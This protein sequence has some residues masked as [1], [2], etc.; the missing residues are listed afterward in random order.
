MDCP[1]STAAWP[2]QVLSAPERLREE[3]FNFSDHK[4]CL[5]AKPYVSPDDGGLAGP[6]CQ[7]IHSC[8]NM[9]SQWLKVPWCP[10]PSGTPMVAEIFSW[11]RARCRSK[12]RLEP[13]NLPSWL[14]CHL[15]FKPLILSFSS[16][17]LASLE[18]V[19]TGGLRAVG[20]RELT[21]EPLASSVRHIPW[22]LYMPH[23]FPPPH[24]AG[25]PSA[26]PLLGHG[27]P[28]FMPS[29]SVILSPAL[30]M[31]PSGWTHSPHHTIRFDHLPFN[32]QTKQKTFSSPSITRQASSH[33]LDPLRRV[34][35]LPHACSPQNTIQPPLCCL[36]SYQ[37]KDL[38]PSLCWQT[39][40][41]AFFHLPWLS[42]SFQWNGP[43]SLLMCS[44][45]SVESDFLQHPQAPL[46]M[47]ILQARVLEWVAMPSSRGSSQPRDQISISYIAGEPRTRSEEGPTR[48][49]KQGG[50]F[51]AGGRGGEQ[52]LL[53]TASFPGWFPHVPHC[54]QWGRTKG[55]KKL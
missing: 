22:D 47:E 28:P 54:F 46:F 51:V 29:P 23:L 41:N 33:F 10:G 6:W 14:V 31:L 49:G 43:F 4:N 8:E 45:T 44:I 20:I 35:S 2:H 39:Q 48:Q 34:V 25:S 36:C 27:S 7:E 13:Q 12:W 37:E 52:G 53:D 38:Q 40:R 30:S 19:S 16:A 55:G 1:F 5:L 32:K 21:P 9:Q 26:S 3:V 50:G 18:S 17:C 11:I 24:N 15:Q 42:I